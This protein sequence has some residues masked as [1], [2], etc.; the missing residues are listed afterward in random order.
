MKAK[1][2]LNEVAES[3]ESAQVVTQRNNP[4]LEIKDIKFPNK[5]PIGKVF[6]GVKGEITE[7]EFDI[8]EDYNS[9]VPRC[10][11]GGRQGTNKIAI[12]KVKSELPDEVYST[13]KDSE[14]EKIPYS[15]Y[16]KIRDSRSKPVYQKGRKYT[17]TYFRLTT[18]EDE[19]YG[20]IE[21][22]DLLRKL[23]AVAITAYL[24]AVG[25]YETALEKR[26]EEMEEKHD[27]GRVNCNSCIWRDIRQVPY[28]NEKG[29]VVD[30]KRDPKVSRL[31]CM[32]DNLTKDDKYIKRLGERNYEADYWDKVKCTDTDC[33]FFSHFY[34]DSNGSYRVGEPDLVPINEDN[35]V[36]LDDTVVDM[37]YIDE[38]D[39][40]NVNP[41]TEFD[42]SGD[43][44]EEITPED[45]IEDVLED[46]KEDR[47]GLDKKQARKMCMLVLDKEYDNLTEEQKGEVLDR[48]I[49]K[50]W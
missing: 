22:G 30:D 35:E 3:E 10:S 32:H 17:K 39:T 44:I 40:Q 37:S 45:K 1:K 33:P 34:K 20:Q 50:E 9:T 48:F 12:Q 27:E 38:C 43:T 25:L 2:F 16:L 19:K 11:V 5:G 6:I 14:V 21:C 24:K 8:W 28:K 13:F 49:D 31:V 36:L 23:R 42:I 7:V 47:E 15:Q 26:Q 46:L 4:E 41:D 29:M 18:E